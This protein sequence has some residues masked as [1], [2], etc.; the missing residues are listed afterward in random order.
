[1][2]DFEKLIQPPSPESSMGRGERNSPT[3]PIFPRGRRLAGT[4]AT[5]RSYIV[6]FICKKGRL[7]IEVDCDSHT[8]R[9]EYDQFPTQYYQARG[10]GGQ[11]AY[12]TR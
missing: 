4:T 6:D 11:V 8:S 1:M 12:F 9:V 2:R 7:V 5:Y 3:R 10:N